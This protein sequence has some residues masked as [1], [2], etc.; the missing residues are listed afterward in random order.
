MIIPDG[1]QPGQYAH[2]RPPVSG[3]VIEPLPTAAA[4]GSG[5]RGEAGRRPHERV[6]A[7]KRTGPR[8]GSRAFVA[9]VRVPDVATV[10]AFPSAPSRLTV[11]SPQFRKMRITA[12]HFTH[13]GASLVFFKLS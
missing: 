13:L 12:R 9:V 5:S 4:D 7:A 1:F 10:C 2:D 11:P 6:L 3:T 8:S